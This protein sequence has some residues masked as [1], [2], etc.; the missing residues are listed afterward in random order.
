MT[1]P[2]QRF[3]FDFNDPSITQEEV[4]ENCAVLLPLP[5]RIYCQRIKNSNKTRQCSTHPSHLSIV[6]S[7]KA[8]SE[9]HG[10]AAVTGGVLKA[11]T[12]RSLTPLLDLLNPM[13][14]V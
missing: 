12:L 11:S 3:D 5:R 1:D 6:G 4:W 2:L 10:G 8:A 14:P 9:E 7:R 13:W